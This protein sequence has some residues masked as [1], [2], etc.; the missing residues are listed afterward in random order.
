MEPMAALRAG[1]GIGGD[2][3]ATGGTFLHDLRTSS[4]PTPSTVPQT[5][6][7]RRPDVSLADRPPA[8]VD[9]AERA[10]VAIAAVPLEFDRPTVHQALEPGAGSETARLGDLSSTDP[11][12]PHALDAAPQG[13]AVDRQARE[14]LGAQAGGPGEQTGG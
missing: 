13:I 7:S 3:G 9:I 8:D 4:D 1:S 11:K 6:P 2:L 5:A 14:R 10:P 12:Q